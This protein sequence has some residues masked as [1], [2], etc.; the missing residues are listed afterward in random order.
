LVLARACFFEGEV[1]V[2]VD[3]DSGD[4]LVAEPE[5]DGR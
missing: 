2:K 1:G 4:L 5:G 3:L